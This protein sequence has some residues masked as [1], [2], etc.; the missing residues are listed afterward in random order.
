MIY[1]HPLAEAQR[2][3]LE[4]MAGILFP[5]VPKSDGDPN[6]TKVIVE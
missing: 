4:Q 3:A 2:R 6:G 5:S 1:T